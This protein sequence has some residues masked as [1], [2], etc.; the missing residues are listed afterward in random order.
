M[1][2][3]RIIS[4]LM[5]VVVA[6]TFGGVYQFYFK[7]KLEE[8]AQNA[9]F[10]SDLEI[11]LKDLEETFMKAK[12]EEV[13]QLWRGNRQPWLDSVERRTKYFENEAWYEHEVYPNDGSILR[14]W[15]DDAS[16]KM[17][18][19]FNTKARAK[20]G[21]NFP[22]DLRINL[23]IPYVDQLAPADASSEQALYQHLRRLSFGIS[24]CELLLDHN[25]SNI[26]NLSLWRKRKVPATQNLMELQTFGVS[27]AMKMSDLIALLEEIRL[28]DNYFTVDAIDISYP[29]IGYPNE[30]QLSVQMLV[31][32]AD[33]LDPVAPGAGG[34]PAAGGGG[35]ATAM[36]QAGGDVSVEQMF[37]QTLETR[38]KRRAEAEGGAQAEPGFFG[39]AWK[40]FKR[41]VLYMN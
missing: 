23:N 25:V 10:K 41:Y 14:F 29:Y 22:E 12:P 33:F 19:E 6:S 1:T 24:A 34:A 27:F 15:Y 32:V 8:Y 30:P 36:A 13:I 26:Q 31:S 39:K 5:L 16:T 17:V 3:G 7:Q 28:A 4:A 18:T 21:Y 11:A 2:R 38:S 35:R 40:L 37:K 20:L 9:K